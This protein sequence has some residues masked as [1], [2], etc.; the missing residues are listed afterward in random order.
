MLLGTLAYSLRIETN[1]AGANP[2]YTALP[3]RGQL[4]SIH[5]RT[6]ESKPDRPL[7]DLAF[8]QRADL[9][10]LAGAIVFLCLAMTLNDKPNRMIASSLPDSVSPTDHSQ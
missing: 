9:V 8:G 10:V 3:S 4:D 1:R 7:L 2:Q 5:S 6:G